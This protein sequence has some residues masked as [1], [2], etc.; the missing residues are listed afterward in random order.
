MKSAIP[1]AI[2]VGGSK[3]DCYGS[4]LVNVYSMAG[5]F[6]PVARV[7]FDPEFANPGWTADK[8]TP[9]IY[10]MMAT[11]LD[12]DA[13]RSKQGS[14]KFW[15]DEELSALP[16]MEYDEAMR[17]RDELLAKRNAPSQ[18]AGAALPT[19]IGVDTPSAQTGENG[20]PVAQDVSPMLKPALEATAKK[21]GEPSS[22]ATSVMDRLAKG[23]EVSLDEIYQIPEIAEV[24]KRPGNPT[25]E[26]NTPERV[27]LRQEVFAQLFAK[28]SQ[29]GL[30]K[31]GD[32]GYNGP[33][34]RERRADIVIGV[35]AAGKSSVL[36]DPLSLKHGSRVIDSDMAKELLPEY[37]G[38]KGAG[39]VHKE[40]SM[41]RDRLLAKATERGENI[42][43]PQV[44]GKLEDLYADILDLKAKGYEV[45]LHLNELS[46]W[47]ATGRAIGR[48]F[49]NGRYIDP[50]LVLKVGD[51]PTRNYEVL[52][53]EGGLLDGYSRYSNDV[54]FGA[55]PIRIEDSGDIGP[56]VAGGSEGRGGGLR[57]DGTG[58]R[59]G[60][61][62][63]GPTN[64][65]VW[66]ADPG[67]LRGGRPDGVGSVEEGTGAAGGQGRQE[68][69]GDTGAGVGAAERGFAG[70]Y[71]RLQGET[72]ASGFHPDG[73]DAYRQVDVPMRDFDGRA[74]PKSA[75]TVMEARATPDSAVETIQKMIADGAL[76]FDSI[77]DKAAL[78]RAEKSIQEA[79][80]K[81]A[82]GAWLEKA[83]RGSTS[84]DLVV[85]GQLLLNNA[86]NSRAT[87]DVVQILSAY[88]RMSTTAA[89]AL[90]AQRVL[91]KMSPEW[92][93]FAVQKS[94]ATYQKELNARLGDDAPT[95]KVDQDLY[96]AYVAAADDAGREAALMDI[97]QAVA[98]QLPASFAEKWNAW[99]Y[100]SMLGNP[101]TH[102]RNIA[103][104]AGFA[105]VRG[106]KNA[107]AWGIEHA[108]D[109]A[110]KAFGGDG[111]E[112]TK[113][114]ILPLVSRLS[115]QDGPLVRACYQDIANVE[116]QL[117]GAGKWSTTP[118]GQI[119]QRKTI[120]KTKPLEAARKFNGKALDVED[121]WF[122]RPVYA[123]ALAGYLKAHK[124]TAQM[125]TEGTVKTDVLDAA[126]AYAIKEA[127]KATYRDANAFS[128]LVAKFGYKGKNKVGKALNVMAEGV[129]PFKRTPANILVRGVEYSPAGLVKGLGEAVWSV[130]RGTKTAAQ[131]IDSVAAGLT[132][133]GLLALGAWLAAM[134]LV[135]GG[136]GS[137]PEDKHRDLTGGQNY[138]LTLPGGTSV[139]LDWL[140]PEAMPFFM[141][142]EAY[143]YA[144]DHTDGAIDLKAIENA[145]IQ[146]TDPL[147]ETS[148][149]QG[150]QDA[151]NEV[152]FADAGTLLRVAAN[153]GM[154]YLTQGLPTLFGQIER[155]AE[156]ERQ[157]TYVDRDGGVPKEV[158]WLLGKAM[159]KLP[160]EYNQIPYIDAWG[161]REETG[162]PL[163]RAVNNL[164][165][166]AYVSKENKTEADME[167]ER[168]MEAGQTGVVPQRPAQSVQICKEYLSAE[169]YVAYAEAKG[170]LS[171][172]LVSEMIASKVYKAMSDADKAKAISDAYGYANAVAKKQVKPQYEMPSEYTKTERMLDAGL[173]FGQWAAMRSGMDADGSGRTSNEE[174]ELY[175]N[176][177]FPQAKR[178]KIIRA[179]KGQ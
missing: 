56:S 141:G 138:A 71:D 8:G 95:V 98:D 111:I 160:G 114:V 128:D 155:T 62:A 35:P 39:D 105:P 14:Y 80:Y 13:V 9:D 83:G 109:T 118:E 40:S 58:L 165:N 154:S 87:G 156:S 136:G 22:Q 46:A 28:G 173:S 31:G 79:G 74:I 23:E 152:K 3:L 15:T 161:R 159:N 131:A 4:G 19:E 162:T 92:Q 52:R 44:G 11:D 127:Q 47:K 72:P 100:L 150:L 37:D 157:S 24:R 97:Y 26:I 106:V 27:Q 112:R 5:G 107:L 81:E 2:S 139:T 54:P 115:A 174:L 151:V 176:A 168:L 102:I 34:K 69:A 77:T 166:P 178:E 169:E 119:E 73:E 130:P 149:L 123:G 144:Q 96:D 103:G 65:P 41:I 25:A 45:H 172:Q 90:Q 85:E 63:G 113:S 179:Y 21:R 88:T 84:K 67:G 89:Q 57:G 61:Q 86:M 110:S 78:S 167:I 99:R 51:A 38:G 116:D 153:A 32:G 158:Q 145:V 29:T 129:L 143:N 171:Y 122:S 140:A 7:K 20:A 82:L 76:S 66:G 70:A 134:G 104:N 49:S 125:L 137:D 135:T 133:T 50:G 6:V 12:A 60:G 64:G 93:L 147:M 142:V 94:L 43:W 59:S 42:V 33:I 163:E 124:V 175:V 177:H 117:L 91:K 75:A 10:V 30:E 164:L 146:V 126:R 120:F 17:Y 170:Q 148:M 48:F 68:S 1:H 121:T 16:L 132:G 18:S 53:K 101:R 108:V 36:V 55:K